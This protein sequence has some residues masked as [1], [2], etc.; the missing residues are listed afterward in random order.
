MV[1]QVVDVVT[2]VGTIL[3]LVKGFYDLRGSLVSVHLWHLNVH[4]HELVRS[5]D[6]PAVLSK[7]F[8]EHFYGDL[9]VHGSVDVDH[10]VFLADHHDVGLN[11]E[12]CV[13]N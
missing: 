1:T 10:L 5:V 2:P 13:I 8:F 11:Q 7:S 6:A 12:V 3:L 4:Q 9:T